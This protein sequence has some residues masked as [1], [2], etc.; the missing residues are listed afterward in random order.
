[1][2]KMR[3]KVLICVVVTLALSLLSGCSDNVQETTRENTDKEQ[4]VEDVEDIED[5]IEVVDQTEEKIEIQAGNDNKAKAQTNNALSGYSAK[6]IEYARV[7]LQIMEYADVEE[8]NVGFDKAG[9]QINPYNDDSVGFL[10]DVIFLTGAYTADG[11]VTYSGNGDGT[12]NLYSVPS[13]WHNTE[14]EEKAMEELTRN[15]AENTQKVSI[16]LHD[17]EDIIKLIKKMKIEK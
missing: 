13:H 4:V 10:E 14:E 1:M 9:T 16:D 6:E 8:L 15:I 5:S 3:R 7:W 17:D 2:L 12:I 11:M